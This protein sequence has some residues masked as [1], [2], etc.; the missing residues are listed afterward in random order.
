MTRDRYDRRMT[1]I[2]PPATLPFTGDPE[3]DA[4]IARDPLA[5]L[6]GFELDQQVPLQKA[7][8]GP[9]ELS[10]RIGGLDASAIA[11]MDPEALEAAFREKPALHR[12]PGTMAG[13]VQ[14]LCRHVT[15][16][17]GGDASR[18][19]S[20]AADGRDLEAR[21]LGIPGIG[22][23]KAKALIG[24]LG[25]RFGVRPPGWED[26]APT[27]P[28]LADVDSAEALATYQDQ[29]RAHKAELRA[30]GA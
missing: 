14:D 3:A 21:L 16:E 12:F 20:K 9:L 5:L 19:W 30:T 11:S 10:R 28:T 4:L 25:R 29:K 6:I 7:F 27:Y 23:M 13:R 8:R 22:P 24:I 2:I 15:A 26:V 18:I 17:Y 1:K